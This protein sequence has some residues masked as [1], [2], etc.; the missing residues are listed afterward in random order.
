M[1]DKKESNLKDKIYEFLEHPKGFWANVTQAFIMLLILLSVALVWIEIFN[2]PFFVKY[3]TDIQVTNAF[4]LFIFTVEYFLRLFSA[5]K[6]LKFILKPLSVVDFFAIFPNYLEFVLPFFIETT[7]LRVFRLLRLLRLSRSLRLLMIIRYKSAF[8]KVMRYK[9]TI[10]EAITPVLILLCALK[11]IIWILEVRGLW[12][13]DTNLNELFGI[14]GFALGIIL[15]EKIEM[16]HTKFLQ[17]ENAAVDLYATLTTFMHLID[18]IHPGNG[19]IVV[20]E[21][22]QKFLKLLHDPN[23]DNTLI[24]LSNEK[25]YKEVA[26]IEPKAADVHNYYLKLLEDSFFC[27]SKKE[28]LTPRAYDTL[29]HQATLLYLVL[30]A[31]FIPGITGLISVFVAGYVL[32]GMYYLTQDMDTIIGGE[33]NLINIRTTQLE[34][35]IKG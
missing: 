7:E 22:T 23:A 6:K 28:H 16:T 10:L 21:W 18:R 20:K 35:L 33:F 32:Y 8:K 15:A 19:K 2:R 26:K 12:V 29:L 27:L 5:P 14:I 3:T 25:L 24:N 31:V 13:R 11:L 1:K 17:V 34:Q 4:I 9:G 30:I